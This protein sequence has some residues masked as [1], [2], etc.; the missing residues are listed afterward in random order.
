MNF[1][2]YG[3]R[4]FI[5]AVMC[6]VSAHVLASDRIISG[7]TYARVLVLVLGGYVVGNVAQKIAEAQ[8]AS[9]S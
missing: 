4:K 9:G 7:D 1:A 6:L 3:S 2:R 5:A 8:T